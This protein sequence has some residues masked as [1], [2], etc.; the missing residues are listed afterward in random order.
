IISPPAVGTSASQ[1]AAVPR[2]TGRSSVDIELVAF[3]I[4][5]CDRVVI[6]PF[7]CQHLNHSGVRAGQQ[8]RLGVNTWA[9]SG[10]RRQLAPGR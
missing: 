5:H 7:L 1:L 4:C 9:L 10:D 3:G 2:G 8:P 6:N